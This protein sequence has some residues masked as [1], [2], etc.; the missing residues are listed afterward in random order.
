MRGGMHA[1]VFSYDLF[2]PA[3]RC[4]WFF[5]GVTLFIWWHWAFLLLGNHLLQ[6]GTSLSLPAWH[7]HYW[8]SMPVSSPVSDCGE[9]GET[10]VHGPQNRVRGLILRYWLCEKWKGKCWVYTRISL[11][12]ELNMCDLTTGHPCKTMVSCPSLQPVLQSKWLF[13]SSEPR[14]LAA[15]LDDVWSVLPRLTCS[16]CPASA[17]T[18][19]TG[20]QD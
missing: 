10:Q 16:W 1:F 11:L 7:I 19:W 9:E 8:I 14:L 2:H 5:Q 13:T 12:L 15:W 4:D 17:W 20:V 18:L 3:C 6:P